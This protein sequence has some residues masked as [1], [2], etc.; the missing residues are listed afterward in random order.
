MDEADRI[1]NS[2]FEKELEKILSIC[3]KERTTYL[4]SATMTKKVQ[5]LERASLK[6]PVKCEV[7]SKYQTVEKLLQYYLFIPHKYK[8]C[9]LVYLLNELQG[10][11]NQLFCGT[12]F[13]DWCGFRSKYYHFLCDV[14]QCAENCP[15]AQKPGLHCYS[16]T[17]TDEPEQASWSSQQIQ[18]KVT[19]NHVG[20]R[21]CVTRTGHTSC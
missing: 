7:S 15:S 21:R 8:D 16:T 4:F 19:F 1:L 9:Y 11:S 17:W 18:V 20:Y 5:K 2:D 12:F 13:N 14:C 6:N 3:P 10:Q